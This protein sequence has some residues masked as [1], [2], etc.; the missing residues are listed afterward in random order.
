VSE[1]R[2]QNRRPD[3][4]A[5]VD[6]R[7]HPVLAHLEVTIGVLEHHDGGVDDHADAEGQAAER[8]RIERIAAEVEQGERADH[9]DRN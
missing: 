2:R 4:F 6:G 3:L 7:G 8:Q 5:A 9:R 1:R